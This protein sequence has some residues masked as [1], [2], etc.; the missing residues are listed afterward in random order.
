MNSIF[1]NEP[2]G[3]NDYIENIYHKNFITNSQSLVLGVD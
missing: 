1:S 3:K 2:R